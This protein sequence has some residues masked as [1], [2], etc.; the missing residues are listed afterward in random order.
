MAITREQQLELRKMLHACTSSYGARKREAE[1][2][3]PV[4][5]AERA[6]QRLLKRIATKRDRV[7]LRHMARYDKLKTD[8]RE[9]IYFGNDLN[10]AL[11]LLKQL[12]A[13]SL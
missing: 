2:V 6:A 1:R 10:K 4:T 11:R 5:A 13:L 3:V 7:R 9:A 12:K 8:T